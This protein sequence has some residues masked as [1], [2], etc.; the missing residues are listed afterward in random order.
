MN[1]KKE[2]EYKLFSGPHGRRIVG[3]LKRQKRISTVL[4]CWCAVLLFTCGVLVYAYLTK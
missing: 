2:D 3:R 1:D 4:G